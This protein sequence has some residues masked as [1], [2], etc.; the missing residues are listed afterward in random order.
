MPK[1]SKSE[2]R[3]EAEVDR[4][5][6]DLSSGCTTTTNKLE[7]LASDGSRVATRQ[8]LVDNCHSSCAVLD[9]HVGTS[10]GLVTFYGRY[11][12]AVRIGLFYGQ[13]A[14]AGAF[15]GSIGMPGNLLYALMLF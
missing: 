6:S 7:D 15:S 5:S 14:V 10:H 13:Y 11:D 2:N 12:M 4:S 3:R 8:T 1:G 9:G